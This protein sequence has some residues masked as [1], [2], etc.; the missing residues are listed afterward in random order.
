[1]TDEKRGPSG[2]EPQ[3]IIRSLSTFGMAF[4][5]PPA[6]PAA[7]PVAPPPSTAESPEE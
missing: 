1:M 4:P 6:E 7:E 3:I 5:D 2:G